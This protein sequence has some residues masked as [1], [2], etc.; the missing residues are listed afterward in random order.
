MQISKRKRNQHTP[1][2]AVAFQ[3]PLYPTYCTEYES[4]RGNKRKKVTHEQQISGV[5]LVSTVKSVKSSQIQTSLVFCSYQTKAELNEY[6]YHHHYYQ[7]KQ[8]PENISEVCL[9]SQLECHATSNLNPGRVFIQNSRSSSIE[10]QDTMG[11]KTSGR[12]KNHRETK[13]F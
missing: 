7:Q 8:D 3:L 2:P 11:K 1:V 9:A 5:R 13:F 6:H 12:F 4:A 10:P